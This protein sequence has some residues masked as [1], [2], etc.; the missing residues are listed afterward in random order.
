[1]SPEPSSTPV[2]H[3][4]ALYSAAAEALAGMLPTTSP[5]TAVL[6]SGT[7]DASMLQG[8][9]ELVAA[10]FVGQL[11]ADVLLSRGRPAAGRGTGRTRLAGLRSRRAAPRT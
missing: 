10:G 9:G 7:R 4:T 6:H 5:V 8:H 3:S 1:M 2:L 11:S